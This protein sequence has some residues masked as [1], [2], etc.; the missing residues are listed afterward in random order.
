MLIK[1]GSALN[2][3][4]CQRGT[5]FPVLLIAEATGFLCVSYTQLFSFPALITIVIA[6]TRMYR[7]LTYYGSTPVNTTYDILP[8][9]ML[10]VI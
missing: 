9:F 6:A 10:T 2:V 4:R 8:L 5:S 1:L 3:S 7:D